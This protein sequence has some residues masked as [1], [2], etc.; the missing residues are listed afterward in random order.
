M[1]IISQKYERSDLLHFVGG[2]NPQAG[3]IYGKKDETCVIV[4]SGGKGGESMGYTDR[5]EED[6][7]FTYVGQGGK[8]NQNEHGPGNSKLISGERSVLLF[9]TEEPTAAQ[10]K[11]RNSRRKIFTFEGIFEVKQWNFVTVKE[12]PRAN[13]KI[14]E[15]SLVRANNIFN[16]SPATTSEDDIVVK[17][18]NFAALRTKLKNQDSKPREGTLPIREY[19]IRSKDIVR[20]AISRAKG[21]CEYCNKPGPFEDFKGN[22]FLEVHHIFR[23]SDDGPDSTKNVAAICPNCHREAHF[24][25]NRDTIREEMADIIQKIEYIL[26]NE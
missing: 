15:F 13:D 26:D 6:G 19:R 5:W 2:G 21:N 4:T 23:L 1:F 9:T 14:I 10:R 8:G 12:G 22:L 16:S 7:S 3:I 11:E 17:D 18:I 20:Y 25:R 24:G